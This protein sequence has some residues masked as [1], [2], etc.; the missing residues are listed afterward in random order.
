MKNEKLEEILKEN[1]LKH[2]NMCNLYDSIKLDDKTLIRIVELYTRLERTVILS[3]DD[4][5]CC[6]LVM[7][8]N[9]CDR[10]VEIEE[11]TDYCYAKR[12]FIR[13]IDN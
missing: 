3:Y 2:R 4:T 12:Y 6:Y 11:F 8:Y 1:P 13:K 9:S 10:V 5:K 7:E